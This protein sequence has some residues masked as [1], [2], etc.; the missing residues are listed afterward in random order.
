MSVIVRVWDAPTRLFHWS[1]VACVVG[2][3]VSG[4]IGGGAMVWH[5]RFGYGVLTLLLF[6]TIWGFQGGHWS[7]FTTFV[8]T[9]RQVLRYLQGLDEPHQHVGHNPLGAISVFAMLVFLALQVTSGLMSDDEISAAGPLT[10]L[11]SSQWV[12][13]ATYYHKEIGKLVLILLVILHLGAIAYY[14]LNRRENLI[15]PMVLGDKSLTFPAQEASD[16]IANRI[17]AAVILL[18]CAMLVAGTVTWL[19]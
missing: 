14:L 1:L 4:Q 12:N 17:K 5:F 13:Y 7:R 2:L 18:I 3:V 6:R 10:R 16:T 8:Y 9:P 11:V 19:G 15:R